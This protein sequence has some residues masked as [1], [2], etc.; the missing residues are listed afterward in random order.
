MRTP[1][2]PPSFSLAPGLPGASR[3][4]RRGALLALSA[5]ALLCPCA[6]GAQVGEARVTV[7]YLAPPGPSNRH[8]PT[9]RA[10]LLESPLVKLPPGAVRPRGWLRKQLELMAQG[11]TGRLQEVS[12]W[13]RRD[14]SAWASPKGEGIAPWEELPYWLKGFVSL[15]YVLGDE[16]L[17]KEASAWI[18]AILSSQD[19]E[20]WFGPRENRKTPDIWPNM[21]AQNA[22]QTHH[23][24]TGD[25]RVLSFLLGYARWLNALPREQLLPGSWQK[26]RGG[27]QLATLYWLYNRTGELWLLDLARGVHERTARWDEG[28]ASWH[29]VNLTQSFRE[30][31][32]YSQQSRDARHVAA[33]ERN[34]REAMDLYGQVPGGMFGADENARPGFGGPR[35]GAET[36]SMVEFMWSFETLLLLSG[37]PLHADRCEEVAFNSLPAASTSDYRAL[38]YLTAPNMPLADASNKAPA[39]ENGGCM[40]AY[41]PGG[42]YRCCQHNVAHG[43]PYFTEHAWMATRGNGLAAVLHAPCEVEAKVGEGAGTR[44]KIVEATDY[45]FEDTVRF[46]IE[47]P[48]PVAF[49]LA[50]RIPRWTKAPRARLNGKDLDVRIG[51]SRFLVIERIWMNGDRVELTFPAEI[52][53][54][55]WEKSGGAVTVDRGP[56]TYSLGIK[57]ESRRF[58]GSDDWPETELLPGS[59][60]NYALVLDP[61]APTAS[62]Q[63]ERAAEVPGQP[64]EAT[65]APVRIKARARRVPE[66]KLEDTI[67]GE[68]QG[69]PV[70]SF[71][72]EEEI[73]LIPMGC[74]R[75]RITVFPV[76]G[77]GPD[78]RV[79]KAPP[80]APRASHVHDSPRA[81]N[82]GIV[83]S[84]SKDHS[85]PR[86]TWWDHR[87][88]REW[89]ELTFERPRTVSKVKVYWFDDT[90][91]GQCR[92]PRAWRILWRHE[93]ALLPAREPTA[94]G[95]EPD[96]FN[97]MTFSPVE[98]DALRL[99]VDL[100]DGYSGG[101]LEWQVE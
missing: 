66:W 60:W 95:V 56:L 32:V 17:Q 54:R 96:R 31:A 9:N 94:A 36:C 83:P 4:R 93:D 74:A 84:S 65:A 34:Y 45:P 6:A 69:S 40:F 57:E 37:D 86:F 97:E 100:Q 70:S 55:R 12:E 76:W 99:E 29:G 38:R 28:I 79:W 72:P 91:I 25:P 35:Q 16:H 7:P 62:F 68:L 24:A 71:Q 89:I 78:A 21:L 3:P 80:P 19:G 26:I 92:V 77:N 2:Y 58:G 50:F 48:S 39:I 75:L 43:W 52:S 14:R 30:P 64:F 87:G 20:G 49:P 18:E 53:V 63:L 44:V 22:L 82:D 11:M 13:C 41:S 88:T 46:S 81:V 27:D 42:R 10:P 67:V 61:G 98:A 59:P 101:V 33:A 23:E 1:N 51:P 5:V 8:Y 85:I 47:V 90:G 15:G 73:T